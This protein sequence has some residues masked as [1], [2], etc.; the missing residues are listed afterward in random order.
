MLFRT[1]QTIAYFELRKLKGSSVYYVP[2]ALYSDYRGVYTD[3]HSHCYEISEKIMDYG[4]LYWDGR[5]G[6]AFLLSQNSSDLYVERGGLIFEA[7]KNGLSTT[8]YYIV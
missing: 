2:P 8:G 4:R 6:V 3:F 7:T 5:R 1:Y